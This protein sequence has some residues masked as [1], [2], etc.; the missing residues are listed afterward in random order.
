MGKCSKTCVKRQLEN[1]Q[2]IDLNDFWPVLSDFGLEN[3]FF[4]FLRMAVLHRFYLELSSLSTIS[5]YR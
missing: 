4:V 3:Q 2:N 5:M 1:R